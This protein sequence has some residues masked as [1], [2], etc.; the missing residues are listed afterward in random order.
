L[1]DEYLALNNNGCAPNKP[2]KETR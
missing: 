1:I 2:A